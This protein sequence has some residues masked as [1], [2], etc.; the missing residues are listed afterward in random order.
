MGPA[1]VAMAAMAAKAPLVAAAAGGCLCPSPLLLLVTAR[2]RG[3]RRR[4]AGCAGTVQQQHSAAATASR[5]RSGCGSGTSRKV[6]LLRV[7]L[8]DFSEG[9]LAEACR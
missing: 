4:A 8:K 7:M 1:R 9:P 5:G 3:W 2:C 6:S